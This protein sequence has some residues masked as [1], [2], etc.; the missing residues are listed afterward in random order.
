MSMIRNTTALIAGGVFVGATIGL[1]ALILSAQVTIKPEAIEL[2]RCKI[3]IPAAES[4]CVSDIIDELQD[5]RRLVEEARRATEAERDALASQ[6]EE[7]GT[8]QAE[9][10]SLSA[11]VSNFNLFETVSLP[12]GSVSTGVRFA[13]VLRPEEWTKAWCYLDSTSSSGLP[14]KITLGNQD[15]GKP[16]KWETVTKAALQDAGI[17]RAQFERAK[18]S[19]KFPDQNS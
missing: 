17:T 3:G 19:C 5:A 7:Y 16:V 11:R 15:A 12:Y 2:I 1:A 14:R 6:I 9:L 4:V 8:R 13:T 10:E 18:K